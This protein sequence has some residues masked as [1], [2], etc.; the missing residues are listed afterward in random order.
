MKRPVVTDSACLIGLEGVRLLDL[1]PALF[2]PVCAPP[3]VV[4]ELGRPLPWLEVTAPADAALVSALGM[5]VDAGEAQAIALACERRL[6]IVLDD[7]R[8]RGV[9]SRLGLEVVGTV[10][11]LLRAK[12]AG[13][14]QAVSPVLD[15]LARLGFHLSEE[16]RNEARRLAGE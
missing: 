10:G 6:E 8:A 4:R 7:R 9:A 12:R 16:L 3:E 1:L 11:V 2:E 13:L 15:E 5:L 14:L